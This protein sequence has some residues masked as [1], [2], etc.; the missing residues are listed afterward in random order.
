MDDGMIVD[1]ELG[2]GSGGGAI[3]GTVVPCL[4]PYC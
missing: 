4:L 1:L 2:R 3:N